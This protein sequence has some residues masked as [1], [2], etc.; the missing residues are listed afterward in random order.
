MTS[1]PTAGRLARITGTLVAATL[2][3]TACGG[4][5]VIE[6]A[7][8]NSGAVST[9][10]GDTATATNE[11]ADAMGG[12]AAQGVAPAAQSV[13]QPAA[14]AETASTRERRPAQTGPQT[15]KDTG[16]VTAPVTEGGLAG[17]VQKLVDDSPLFGGRAACRPATLSPVSIGNVSTLSGVLGEVFAPARTSLQ[18]FVTAQNA[19]GGLNGHPIQ[20]FQEDD[21]G[22]PSTAV[23][24]VQTLIEQRKVL[25][26]VGNIQVLTLDAIVPTIKRSGIPVIGGDI[27]NNTWYTNPLIFPQGPTGAQGVAYGY[28]VG[29][30]QYHQ[31]KIVGDIWCIEVPRGCEQ[32]NRAMRE[33]APQM[34]ATFAKDVQVSITA[35]SYVQQCLQFKDAKVEALALTFDAASMVRLA[36]SCTQVGYHPKLMAYPLA[37]GNQKQFLGNDWLGDTYVPLNSFPWMGNTTPVEKYFQATMKRYSPGADSGMAATIGWS[38]GALL[39]AASAGLSPT[40]PTTQQLLDTLYQF[41]GQKFTELGGMSPSPLTFQAAGGAKVPYCLY[42]VVSNDENTGWKR[43]VSTPTCTKVVAPSDPQA[44]ATSPTRTAD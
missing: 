1:I 37:L 12:T 29:A 8:P 27:T 44:A 10:P 14:N 2:I 23:T 28:L 31:K 26:F 6:S 43:V 34:G 24:K 33:L 3:V 25:A 39:V 42:S 5:P 16:R 20:F 36:R 40:N 9:A 17:A 22:D 32:I 11:T 4:S 38:A 7:G 35:P 30:T 13:A 19:C 18:T 15:G 21:Q 41:K